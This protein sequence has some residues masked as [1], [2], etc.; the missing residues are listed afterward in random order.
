MAWGS[1]SGS[2]IYIWAC[3]G[4]TATRVRTCTWNTT[5]EASLILENTTVYVGT[6]RTLPA[7]DGRTTVVPLAACFFFGAK[8]INQ[9]RGKGIS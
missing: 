4:M 1:K 6:A 7:S 8:E 5:L 3:T 9:T 2:A